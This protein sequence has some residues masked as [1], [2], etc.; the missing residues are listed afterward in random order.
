VDIICSKKKK[1]YKD[2]RSDERVLKKET[3]GAER[4]GGRGG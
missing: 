3:P 4:G 2:E 1:H